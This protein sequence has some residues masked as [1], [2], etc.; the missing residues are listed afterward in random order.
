MPNDSS[1]RMPPVKQQ[2]KAGSATVGL[3]AVCV[4]SINCE[5]VCWAEQV[6]YDSVSGETGG[7]KV[8]ILYDNSRHAATRPVLVQPLASVLVNAGRIRTT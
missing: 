3:L 2:A 7:S 6:R 5:L 1:L 4:C 8:Y